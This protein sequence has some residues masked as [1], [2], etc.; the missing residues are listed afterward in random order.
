[1][2]RDRDRDHDHGR[3]LCL[4]LFP[5]PDAVHLCG[6][7]CRRIWDDGRSLCRAAGNSNRKDARVL[8]HVPMVYRVI[9]NDRYRGV[10]NDQGVESR[11]NLVENV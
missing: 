11:D 1:M 2:T 8:G 3:V 9:E 10:R 6:S 5:V 7:S 4:V